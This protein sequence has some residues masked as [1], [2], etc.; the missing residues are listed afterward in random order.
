M[1]DMNDAGATFDSAKFRQVLS[2]F[3]SGVTVITSMAG[4]GPV[5][6][7]VSSFASV[8]LEPPQVLFC[9]K[10]ESGTWA[11][12]EPTGR[13]CVNILAADQED[14]SRVFAS[15][16]PDKFAELGWKRS[17]GGSPVL[18]GVLGF[19]DCSID[20]VVE[21][22]DHFVVIGLVTDL[23]VNHEGGPLVYFRSG[24]GTFEV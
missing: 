12:M 8:S 16:V 13:F 18:D 11:A 4:E 5:G 14:V 3:P 21:A 19:I 1:N 15:R 17:S 10:K 22:G 24:Y 20:Q 23:G 2:H 6:L 7:A 9:I